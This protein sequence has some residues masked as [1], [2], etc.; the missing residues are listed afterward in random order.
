[1]HNA[2]KMVATGTLNLIITFVISHETHYV[3]FSQ[4]TKTRDQ[5]H[6]FGSVDLTTL[7]VLQAIND[8]GHKDPQ[9]SDNIR[10]FILNPLCHLPLVQSL[11]LT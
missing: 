5:D 6:K 2:T 1:M 11:T 10:H 7:P 3:T 8:Y 4:F 9:P